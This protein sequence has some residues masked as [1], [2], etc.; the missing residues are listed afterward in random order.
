LEKR[1]NEVAEILFNEEE[2]ARLDA[3][4]EESEPT[5]HGLTIESPV[6]GVT[7]EEWAT[8]QDYLRARVRLFALGS[9]FFKTAQAAFEELATKLELS[10]GDDQHFLRDSV[11]EAFGEHVEA[12]FY[13]LPEELD[14]KFEVPVAPLGDAFERAQASGDVDRAGE[15][16][17]ANMEQHPFSGQNLLYWIQSELAG[18]I[19]ERLAGGSFEDDLDELLEA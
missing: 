18:G 14:E 5:T 6:E 8:V 13:G 16:L 9:M 12:N 15:L 1:S 10:E 17:R 7:A 11:A 4:L 19:A 2:Q 3:I